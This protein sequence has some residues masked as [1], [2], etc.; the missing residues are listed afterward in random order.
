MFNLNYELLL[1][2][3]L[4]IFAWKMK[5]K[6]LLNFQFITLYFK[7]M[8][9]W[10]KTEANFWI[11]PHYKIRIFEWKTRPI[12]DLISELF[13]TSKYAFL[14]FCMANEGKLFYLI[15]ELFLTSKFG[16]FAW[17]TMQIL[18][19]ICELLY[20]IIAYFKIMRFSLKNEAN[21]DLIFEIF[22]TSILWILYEKRSKILNYSSLQNKRSILLFNF[23]SIRGSFGI[24]WKNFTVYLI[25][26]YWIGENYAFLHEKRSRFWIFLIWWQYLL[27][28]LETFHLRFWV[29]I[30]H[31]IT[32]LS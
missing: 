9:F 27:W 13:L 25:A 4:C 28:H 8:Q 24:F 18:N 16:I 17:K 3:K 11:T 5:K 20:I 6:N 22:L 14:H 26:E 7:I 29:Q 15:S 32:K 19:V 21:V 30:L 31:L 10:M 12:F 23:C 1:T 2:S